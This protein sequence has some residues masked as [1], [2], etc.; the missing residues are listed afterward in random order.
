MKALLMPGAHPMRVMPA[1]RCHSE[2]ASV[3]DPDPSTRARV[4]PSAVVS[5]AC[6]GNYRVAIKDSPEMA[7]LMFDFVFSEA[8]CPRTRRDTF[9]QRLRS[10]VV[11]GTSALV[12]ADDPRRGRSRV[13]RAL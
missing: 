10:A 7:R 8:E 11:P 9:L 12:L 5:R 3:A 2:H 6:D 4:G 13:L 1:A